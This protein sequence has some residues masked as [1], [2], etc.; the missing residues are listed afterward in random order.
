[1][2]YLNYLFSFLICLMFPAF[3]KAQSSSIIAEGAQLQEVSNQFSFTEGP[4]IDSKGNVYFTD[5]PN[6]KIWLYDIHGELSLFMDKAGRSN[7]MYFDQDDNLYTCADEKNEIWKINK[8]SKVKVLVK[9]FEEKSFNGPNDL[10]V[11]KKGFIYFTDPYYQRSYW[12]RKSPDL[13][14]MGLYVLDRKQQ[15]ILLDKDFNRPNGIV[16]TPDGKYLYVADIGDNKI[17]RYDIMKDGTLSNK[18]LFAN[19]GSDGMTLDN[20]GNLYLTGNVITVYNPKGEKI[21]QIDVPAKW[22]ANV[23]FYGK[24]RN[25]LF[26]TASEKIFT[27]Q[28]RVKA[29]N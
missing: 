29:A 20:Q 10:W 9:S 26:V 3:I 22:T 27:L 5:Q 11:S 24:D 21:E 14:H 15:V 17:Y 7:G 23:S 13:N 8:N 19:Q 1:M 2:I 12:E 4:A 18:K 6:N 28:M 16:G 25:I